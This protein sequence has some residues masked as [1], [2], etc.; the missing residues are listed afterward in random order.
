M[1]ETA[2]DEQRNGLKVNWNWFKDKV[3]AGVIAAII[4]AVLAFITGLIQMPVRITELKAS[5][6]NLKLDMTKIDHSVTTLALTQAQLRQAAFD[7]ADRANDLQEASDAFTNQMGDLRESN[8]SLQT[9]VKVLSGF[10]ADITEIRKKTGK[11]GEQVIV[12][13]KNI[14]R[15]A[16]ELEDLG[17]LVK[18]LRGLVTRSE[19]LALGHYLYQF[20]VLNKGRLIDSEPGILEFKIAIPRRLGKIEKFVR[21]DFISWPEE[22]RDVSVQAFLEDGQLR[23]IMRGEKQLDETKRFFDKG[24]EVRIRMVFLTLR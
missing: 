19:R 14:E 12:L 7:M 16:D 5:V 17:E 3:W 15:H 20:D 2:N 4:L 23:L 13:T 21:V 24:G 8:G 1:A 6:D 10:S 22:W 11:L 9:S 18:Q